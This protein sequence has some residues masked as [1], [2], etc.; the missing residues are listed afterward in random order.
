MLLKVQ[1]RVFLG[2]LKDTLKEVREV[3][4]PM[5]AAMIILAVLCLTVG[6]WFYYFINTIIEP[7]AVVLL[8]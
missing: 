4:V 7:A 8:G 5:Q 6:V 2:K 3:A 1:S